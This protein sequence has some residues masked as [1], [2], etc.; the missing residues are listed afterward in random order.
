VHEKRIEIRWRDLD[1]YNHVNN[2]VYLTY[3][4]EARDEWLERTL[5]S[6]GAAWGYVIARVAIDFR[7]EL[8][9]TDDQIVASCALARLG[10][11]SVTTREE[12]RTAAGELAAEAEAVLV[13]VDEGS[14]KPRPLSD[15]ER[16]A[17]SGEGA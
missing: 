3:L 14:G 5:G 9:Q 7:R 8:T 10:T 6:E 13:A 1:A 12:L 11:S 4:E 16:S 17:L 15:S 2:A